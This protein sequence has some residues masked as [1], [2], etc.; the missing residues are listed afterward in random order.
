[1][2]KYRLLLVLTAAIWGFAFVAQV[3]AMNDIGPFTFSAARSFIG[4]ISLLPILLLKHS[5]PPPKKTNLPAGLPLL[6]Q[7]FFSAA[8]RCFSR[9]DYYIPRLP[10]P[11]LLLLPIFLWFLFSASF[12]EKHCAGTMLLVPCSP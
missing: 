4:A 6:L 2:L 12:W 11:A 1:M 8:E 3:V 5:D 9:S 7:D 10:K